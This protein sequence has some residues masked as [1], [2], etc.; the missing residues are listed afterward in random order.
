MTTPR[1]A[2]CVVLTGSATEFE[3]D[4]PFSVWVDALDAYVASQELG[5][6]D[7]WETE[8]VDELAAIIPS[9]KRKGR[10]ALG[11]VSR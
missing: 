3:R 8:L 11:S 7:A 9:V 6:A 5:L 1:N 10:S 4:Q 2:G